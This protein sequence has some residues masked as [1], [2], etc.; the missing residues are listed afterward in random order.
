[1]NESFHHFEHEHEREQQHSPPPKAGVREFSGP[2]EIIR[3]DEEQT[4]VPPEIEV[5]LKRTLR[6]EPRPGRPWWKRFL[7]QP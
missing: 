3:H 6:R 7:R 2:E 4:E 1:M 5:R